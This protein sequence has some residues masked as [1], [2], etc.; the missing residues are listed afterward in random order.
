MAMEQTNFSES[1]LLRCVMGWVVSIH[2]DQLYID[3]YCSLHV[4][5]T[6]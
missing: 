1:T 5:S 2:G 6:M 3:Q 4:S